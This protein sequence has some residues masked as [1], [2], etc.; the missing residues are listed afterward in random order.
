MAGIR[1][2]IG[3]RVLKNKLKSFQR[4]TRVYNFDN[5]EIIASVPERQKEKSYRKDTETA[6]LETIARRPCTLDDLHKI[7]GMHINEINKYLGVLEDKKKIT[8]VQL[9]RGIFYKIISD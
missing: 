6:I 4:E 7:L 2:T 8:N 5:A 1:E 3:K 9:E